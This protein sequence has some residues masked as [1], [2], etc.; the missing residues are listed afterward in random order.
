MGKW[1]DHYGSEDCIWTKTWELHSRED[2]IGFKRCQFLRSWSSQGCCHRWEDAEQACHGET[3]GTFLEKQVGGKARKERFP[4]KVCKIFRFCCFRQDGY[5]QTKHTKFTLTKVFLNSI[6]LSFL[7]WS[8]I[9]TYMYMSV[10]MR[11]YTY[12]IYISSHLAFWKTTM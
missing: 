4:L 5:T 2:N 7:N 10:V 6:K 1:K 9:N 8:Y 3:T 12:K 11:S